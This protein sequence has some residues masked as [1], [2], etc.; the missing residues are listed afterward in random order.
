MVNDST[1][2]KS[3]IPNFR[4]RIIDLTERVNEF[5]DYGFSGETLRRQIKWDMQYIKRICECEEEDR[6]G[7]LDF[8][9]NCLRQYDGDV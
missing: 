5:R 7:Y 1:M 8:Y 6:R 2:R 3:L 4:E 9:K